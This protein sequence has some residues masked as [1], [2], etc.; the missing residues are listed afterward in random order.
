MKDNNDFKIKVC[1]QR[2]CTF[3]KNCER[4]TPEQNEMLSQLCPICDSCNA[5][6]NVINESCQNCW[7]CLKDEGFVRSGSPKKLTEGSKILTFVE[8][9]GTPIQPHVLLNLVEKRNESNNRP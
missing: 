2:L 6:N 5:E 7:N 8:E 4:H 1:D 9:A 3:N